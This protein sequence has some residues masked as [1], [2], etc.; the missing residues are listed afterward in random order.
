MNIRKVIISFL[1]FVVI[2]GIAIGMSN[3]LVGLKDPPPVKISTK[4]QKYVKAY[5]ATYG[6]KNHEIIT[7]G[8]VVS[9]HSVD[10]SAEVPGKLLE[11]SIPLKKGSSFKKGDLLFRLDNTTAALSLQSKKSDYINT[12]SQILADIKI[13]YPDNFNTWVAFLNQLDPKKPLPELPET[14]SVQEKTFVASKAI[15]TQYYA[16]KSDEYQ[17]S[18][19]AVRAPFN[20]T[21]SEVFAEP[22]AIINASTKV[23]RLID[24]YN[25]EIEVPLV[26]QDVSAIQ[27]GDVVTIKKE[28]RTNKA[29]IVR[30]ANHL[31]AGSQSINV[32]AAFKNDMSNPFYD[33]D[34]VQCIINKKED[35]TAMVAPRSAIVE[36]NSVYII[37]ED[38]TLE[39]KP[40]TVKGIA[41]NYVF[42]KGLEDSTTV[43]TEP[44]TKDYISS[45]V[46][47][48]SE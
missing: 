31:D 13:D 29:K 23:I 34:Y 1:L 48:I 38:S 37:K 20:G 41:E 40:I 3:V 44:I 6:E 30:I 2:I 42:F 32:Y 4:P 16:I 9:S 39:L 28:D 21:I 8:R 11:G 12:V 26:P 35:M 45:K 27:K 25:M 19:Y 22:G 17:L 15:Y 5:L 33:G 14:K 10:F 43:V 18:K 47:P 36:G 7:F 24:I 46:I